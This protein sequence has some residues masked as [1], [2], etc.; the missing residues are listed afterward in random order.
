METIK[1]ILNFCNAGMFYDYKNIGIIDESNQARKCIF[2]NFNEILPVTR[3]LITLSI[4]DV[5]VLKIHDNEIENVIENIHDLRANKL[6][7]PSFENVIKAE[8][9]N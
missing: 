3:I 6:Y 2:N 8:D 4:I 9:A 5:V 7:L 1:D